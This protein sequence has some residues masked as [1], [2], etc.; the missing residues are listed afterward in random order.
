MHQCDNTK[1]I[2]EAEKDHIFH[3]QWFLFHWVKF[4]TC[5][6]I[7]VMSL[8][9]KYFTCSIDIL[10]NW[11]MTIYT[12]KMKRSPLNTCF[13]I[14]TCLNKILNNSKMTKRVYKMKMSSFKIKIRTFL[15]KLEHAIWGR[16][17]SF[18]YHVSIFQQDINCFFC[19][20]SF[21]MVISLFVCYLQA[22]L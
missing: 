2:L 8:F 15:N 16:L 3:F 4:R 12:D 18:C 9:L 11:K 17:I 19:F 13:Y 21:L 6:E 14:I 1:C 22:T 7:I 5:K 10:N 20:L